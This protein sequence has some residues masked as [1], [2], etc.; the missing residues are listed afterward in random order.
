M[1]NA[2]MHAGDSGL[3]TH[4]GKIQNNPTMGVCCYSLSSLKMFKQMKTLVLFRTLVRVF[5]GP[6]SNGNSALS[7][8]STSKRS[9][10]FMCCVF[11]LSFYNFPKLKLWN[12][13]NSV[14]GG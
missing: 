9:D 13:K 4:S 5:R 3:S 2:V 6:E 12:Q 10:G 14:R 7:S 11:L 1:H 8:S